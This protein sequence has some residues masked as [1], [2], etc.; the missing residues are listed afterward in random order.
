[1]RRILLLIGRL[2]QGGGTET[3]VLTL[4][5]TFQ[6]KGYT[7]GV[8][9]AGGEWTN[10]FQ[11]KGIRVHVSPSYLKSQYQLREVIRS[12]NYQVIHANDSESLILLDKA[13]IKSVPVIVTIHGKYVNSGLVKR[14]GS[15][16]KA[17]ITVS[18]PVRNYV[19]RCGV[20]RN[21]VYI[22]PN[23]ISA[24]FNTH[25]S[26]QLRK[27][28]GIPDNAF[29]I[30][31]A[32]RFT[33]DKVQLSKR[34]SGVLKQFSV[35]NQNVWVLIAGRNSQTYIKEYQHCRVL[36]HVQNMSDFYNA[37]DVMTGTAR[38][39]IEALSCGIPTIAVGNI[40]YIGFVSNNNLNL[41]SK[42]NFGDHGSNIM[43]W[44]PS[45][46]FSDLKKI[47][48][49]KELAIKKTRSIARRIRYEYSADSMVK[50]ILNLY[51]M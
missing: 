36:G 32:G 44:N 39:A 20:E 42:T 30:G 46:L 10:F 43:G 48:Q 6:K 33:F 2:R 4:A 37:C 22:I 8:F 12:Y 23:G 35:Q 24:S 16:A 9:T 11:K 47:Y 7:V 49:S 13:K 51:L 50:Q 31:Y 3:Y 45:Q 15:L 18:P 34:I 5:E 25:R 40:R 29:V 14:V 27:Q 1:M 19:V 26:M 28:L 17:V 41:A 21:K 38:V